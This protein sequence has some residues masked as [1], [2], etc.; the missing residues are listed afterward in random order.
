[1]HVDT[2]TVEAAAELLGCSRR[3]VFNLLADGK[4][5]RAARAGRTLKILRDSIDRF[6][7]G[8]TTGGRRR[9]RSNTIV[10]ERVNAADFADLCA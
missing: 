3:Q 1:M 8:E 5:K 2:V 6:Q 7:L 4:L 9:R 10:L